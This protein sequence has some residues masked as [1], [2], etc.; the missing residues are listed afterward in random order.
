MELYKCLQKCSDIVQCAGREE[1]FTYTTS[2]GVQGESTS[3]TT[4]ADFVP[5]AITECI[6]SA[7]ERASR[8]EQCSTQSGSLTTRFIHLGPWLLCVTAPV[9]RIASRLY[10]TGRSVGDAA[11][12]L[13]LRRR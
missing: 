9:W 3:V 8:Q 5:T 1:T 10:R 2:S 6:A 11:T 7:A 4:C 13:L 12:R